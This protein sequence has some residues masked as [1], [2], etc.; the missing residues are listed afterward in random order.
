MRRF[1]LHRSRPEITDRLCPTQFFRVKRLE[2]LLGRTVNLCT[3]PSNLVS[4]PGFCLRNILQ[5]GPQYQARNGIEITCK[6][7]TTQPQG[8]KRNR[9]ASGRWID[10]EWRV[11]TMRRLHQPTRNFEVVA[12]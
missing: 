2:L 1:A 10:H 4:K 3:D 5:H 12:I 9:S 11:L 6:G 8:F 7:V